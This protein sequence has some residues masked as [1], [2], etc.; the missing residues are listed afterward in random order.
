MYF[1][2]IYLL[3]SI[4]IEIFVIIDNK[5]LEI[6]NLFQ[7]SLIFRRL[8]LISL[9]VEVKFTHC[10]EYILL[11]LAR[12]IDVLSCRLEKPWLFVVRGM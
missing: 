12:P 10:R 7:C 6:G 2:Y 4:N 11:R 1:H 9:Y 5:K 8:K 3:S